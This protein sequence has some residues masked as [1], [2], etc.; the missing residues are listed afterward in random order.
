M[1]L[2]APHPAFVWGTGYHGLAVCRSLGRRGIPVV[3]FTGSPHDIV[4]QSRY[5]TRVVLLTEPLNAADF[6]T[7]ASEES[8]RFRRQPVFIPIQDAYLELISSQ[9]DRLAAHGL[10][11]LPPHA[12]VEIV[13]DK[14]R[15]AQRCR[16]AGLPIPHTQVLA[17]HEDLVPAAEQLPFPAVLKPTKSVVWEQPRVVEAFHR[18]K[19]LI[20]HDKATFLAQ[21]RRLLTIAGPLVAQELVPG[22]SKQEFDYLSFRSED[23]HRSVGLLTEKLRQLPITGGSGS[24]RR[25]VVRSRLESLAHDA[26]DALGW[27]GPSEV[28][29]KV[30]ARTDT[31]RLIEVNGRLPAWCALASWC[32]VDFPHLVYRSAI[33]DH[34]ARPPQPSRP[35][36]YW[37]VLDMDVRAARSEMRAGGLSVMAWLR[38][39]LRV[40]SCAELARDD[41]TPIVWALKRLIRA[42]WAQLASTIR[43]LIPV[44]DTA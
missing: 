33:G 40:R 29:L 17:A 4:A 5:V 13:S 36:G 41:W 18:D 2:H 25:L 20:V 6:V 12:R 22:P 32:D 28:S 10:V 19:I 8:A 31:P 1:S 7:V 9:R 30:D 11:D 15:F 44:R 24:L 23:S 27:T 3:V 39:L 21:G 42:P 35:R 38:S 37:M 16:R 14:A 34:G 26:L 43:R